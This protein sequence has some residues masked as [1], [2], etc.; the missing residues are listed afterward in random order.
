MQHNRGGQVLTSGRIGRLNILRQQVM[1]P[2]ETIKARIKGEVRMEA[3]RE[4]DALRMNAHLAV[5]VQPIR[6]LWTQWP[7]YVKQGPNGPL[8][9]PLYTY[10][11]FFNAGSNRFNL[12]QTYDFGLGSLPRGNIQ[13]TTTSAGIRLYFVQSVLRIFN[14]WYK[15][16]EFNNR[17]TWVRDGA[18]VVPLRAAWSRVRQNALPDDADTDV[19]SAGNTLSVVDLAQIQSR[20]RNAMEREVLSFDRYLEI[21]KDLWGAGGS[22][23]VDRVPMKCSEASVG[24]DPREYH[25]TNSGGLGQWMSL[26]DFSVDHMCP[27]ITVPEHSILTYC[28]VLR[29]PSIT[30]D[31]QNPM[32]P[33]HL[34]WEDT[35]GDPGLL[36]ARPPQP[37]SLADFFGTNSRAT[38]GYLPSGW[39][40]RAGWNSIGIRITE[41]GS[42]PLMLRPDSFGDS[43]RANRVV[44]AFRSSSL[45]DYVAD[46]F[47]TEMSHSPISSALTSYNLGVG[48]SG[49]GDRRE[50]I[51]PK[52]M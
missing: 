40:W 14:Q 5:F 11:N 34:S 41:R 8:T 48:S 32:A 25:A 38:I 51:D 6:W 36:A 22:R 13:S 50:F 17:A 33:G 4:R 28:L 3:L 26:Y 12:P 7:R 19:S 47:F 20:F 27:P 1:L 23:E 24:V 2:G 44:P 49:R 9:P 21:I 52:V 31:D 18:P 16:P 35:V 10:D 30:A 46:L 45:G 29:F 37:V 15:W 43:K 42:F 39:Q